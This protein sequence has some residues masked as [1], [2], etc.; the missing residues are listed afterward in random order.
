M[1]LLAGVSCSDHDEPTAPADSRWPTH[2]AID[3]AG[4]DL[5]TGDTLPVRAIV[6]TAGGD[7]LETVSF[8][9]W[10]VE[11]P[12]VARDTL[13][14]WRSWA[15]SDA[16]PLRRRTLPLPLEDARS[17]EDRAFAPGETAL[18]ALVPAASSAGF[19]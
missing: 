9:S 14:G 3:P 11:P 2:I 12:R 1:T 8:L 6:T 16:D 17:V 18:A 15:G 5:R 4:A 19:R 13:F 10:G 7:T